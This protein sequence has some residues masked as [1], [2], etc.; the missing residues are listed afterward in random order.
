VVNRDGQ[1]FARL[2]GAASVFTLVCFANY[3]TP[4]VERAQEIV[5]KAK[6]VSEDHTATFLV[7]HQVKTPAGTV[8]EWASDGGSGR[9]VRTSTG[10]SGRSSF[11]DG[12]SDNTGS[13]AGN[14]FNALPSRTH[15]STATAT[16]GTDATSDRI[17]NAGRR[18]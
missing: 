18:F 14:G 17:A 2:F 16:T 4:E 3:A 11:A 13:R 7:A 9:T 10:R 8:V 1:L 15:E 12:S 5:R 6:N